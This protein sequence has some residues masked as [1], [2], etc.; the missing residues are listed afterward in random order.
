M[1]QTQYASKYY[2][3]DYGSFITSVKDE[4]K[5]P[6]ELDIVD[7]TY[8]VMKTHLDN[9]D[10]QMNECWAR[11]KDF[12]VRK[13]IV[14]FQD[15]A[16]ELLPSYL[17]KITE[18]LDSKEKAIQL[19]DL[20]NRIEDMKN[21]SEVFTN[22]YNNLDKQYKKTKA[23][24]VHTEEDNVFL[25]SQVKHK[26]NEISALNLV[27]ESICSMIERHKAFNYFNRLHQ[28]KPVFREEDMNSIVELVKSIYYK[29]KRINKPKVQLE[30]LLEEQEA[31]YKSTSPH[32][33]FTKRPRRK[34]VQCSPMD[35]HSEDKANVVEKLR[36]KNSLLERRVKQLNAQ[37]G[38]QAYKKNELKD[39]FLNAIGEVKSMIS[40]R[41]FRAEVAQNLKA[42]EGKS[43]A[44]RAAQF[45]STVTRLNEI[46]KPGPLT[47]V[48]WQD[49][50][51][52]DKLNLVT[53]VVCNKRVLM[54]LYGVLFPEKE[55]RSNV[56]M[57]DYLFGAQENASI[58][59]LRQ[60]D[61]FDTG[62]P[63]SLNAEPN[64]A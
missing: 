4:K 25:K 46:L 17:R 34:I 5:L 47:H 61:D 22:T 21:E 26:V 51:Q 29:A 60:L 2:Y 59:K 63:S 37:K 24:N 23:M 64:Q 45:Q 54:Q 8:K 42:S 6:E 43:R 9:F 36:R 50:T 40:R 55:G 18:E 41:K 39:I 28:E 56:A 30:R 15:K 14:Q 32:T 49:F 10:T 1:Q 58:R 20:R 44:P 38:I 62:D 57:N 11:T 13:C 52:E 19:N 35:A 3:K 53:L 31:N 27:L 7:K 33:N 12:Y 16:K 48:K